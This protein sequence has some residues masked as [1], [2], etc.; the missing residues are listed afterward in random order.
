MQFTIDLISDLNLNKE[1]FDW[2]GKPT[3]LFCLVAGNISSDRTILLETLQH[4][5]RQYHQ[6]FFIDGP[7]DMKREIVDLKESYKELETY[8]PNLENIVY[9]N[10]QVI[11]VNNVGIVLVNG[12]WS[13]DF[14]SNVEIEQVEQFLINEWKID[15]QS[16]LKLACYAYSDVKYLENT[17]KKLQSHK[18]VKEIMI[19]SNTVP[20]VDLIN[21]DIELTNSTK[22][23]LMGNSMITNCLNFD[24]KKKVKTWCFGYYPHAIDESI[25][26]VRFVSNPRSG[27]INIYYPKVIQALS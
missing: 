25:N 24:T 10:N 4:L 17:I 27:D 13:Y 5:G 8:I 7:E 23:N 18:D 11:M 12:W 3:S 19:V 16:M 9:G 26:G 21:H 6:V 20:L 14:D 1:S 2:I 22:M 15:R